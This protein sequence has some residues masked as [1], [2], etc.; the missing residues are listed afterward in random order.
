MFGIGLPE[1]IV[2][3]AVALIVVGPDKLP[4]LARSLA[5]GM[6]ELK[7]TVDEV[8]VSLQEEGVLDEV[9][10]EI[11]ETTHELNNHLLASDTWEPA[12]DEASV[13][14]SSPDDDQFA[15]DDLI[16]LEPLEERPWETERKH[17]PDPGK[18]EEETADQGSPEPEPTNM[19]TLPDN[20]LPQAANKATAPNST[21]PLSETSRST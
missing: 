6:Q 20:D 5:R 19:T 7:K 18:D 21:T 15:E 11:E 14:D 1:M 9:Q 8:K 3:L 2:I 13:A 12:K 4:D 16:D 10:S 17:E